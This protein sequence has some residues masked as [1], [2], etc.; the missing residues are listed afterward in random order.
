MNMKAIDYSLRDEPA[1]EAQRQLDLCLMLLKDAGIEVLEYITLPDFH[2]NYAGFWP[3]GLFIR[4]KG[5]SMV[6]NGIKDYGCGMSIVPLKP[7]EETR[8]LEDEKWV[9]DILKYR[10]GGGNHFLEIQEVTHSNDGPFDIGSHILLLHSGA[11]DKS[12]ELQEHERKNHTKKS[13]KGKVKLR[14]FEGKGS[15]DDLLD[16]ITAC[17]TH[18]ETKRT[19]ILTD[20]GLK[21][22][23]IDDI[24]HNQC[25]MNRDQSIT[26]MVSAN[27]TRG[28]KVL[29]L[30]SSFSR[31]TAY[32]EP[33]GDLPVLPHGTGRILRRTHA[34]RIITTQEVEKELESAG[35]KVIY[36]STSRFLS[37]SSV[38]YRPLEPMLNALVNCGQV[39]ALALARPIRTY[40]I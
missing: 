19:I 10:I 33:I 18:A 20:L 21:D 23:A 9:R 2:P 7:G 28:H 40:K 4:M 11:D 30:P 35:N 39:K 13:S 25:F 5:D 3:D 32:I 37:E 8:F 14:L 34:K 24:S 38:C 36:D 6:C 1:C 22:R 12:Q 26:F 15:M 29:P 27:P 16:K 17:T 31:P